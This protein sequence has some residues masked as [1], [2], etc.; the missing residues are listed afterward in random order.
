MQFPVGNCGKHTKPKSVKMMRTG[1]ETHENNAQ[2]HGNS[3]FLGANCRGNEVLE[4][5]CLSLFSSINNCN[6][7]CN[8]LVA[9]SISCS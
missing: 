8:R 7:L 5:G 1:I 6:E 3:A 4:F 9:D 2:I